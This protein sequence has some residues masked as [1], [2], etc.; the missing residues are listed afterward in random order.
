MTES[1]GFID[2]KVDGESFKTFYKTF[3]DIK[4]S[5]RRPLVLLH[6]G[7]GISHHYMLPHF[8]LYERYG[9]PLIIYDQI[10]IG[11]STHLPNKPPSF[12]TLDLFMDELENV[13]TQLGV[14]SDFDLLGHSWGGM[15]ASEFASKRAPAGLNRLVIASSLAS[16]ELWTESARSL[17]KQLPKELQDMLAKHEAEGTTDSPEYQEGMQV[18]YKKFICT[19]EPWPETLQTSF[20]NMEKDPTVYSTM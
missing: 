14:R 16:M 4:A 5:S 15:L 8:E 17:L 19:T 10:G 3:G 20:A 7:P 18:F 1:T 2:F 13:L 11:E 9:F 6:G 12:W